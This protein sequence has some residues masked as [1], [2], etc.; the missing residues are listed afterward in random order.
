[1]P[2]LN[3]Y[4]KRECK[5]IKRFRKY[6][7]GNEQLNLYKC[8]KCQTILTDMMIAKVHACYCGS[9]NMHG[10]EKLTKME[11]WRLGWR[12]ILKGY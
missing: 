4:L 1:M 12:L 8:D 5:V 9:K 10:F 3:V 6:I 2:S 7:L 11:S